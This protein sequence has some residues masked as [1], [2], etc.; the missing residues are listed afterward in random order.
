[1]QTH[2]HT[3]P[4][5]SAL[6]PRPFRRAAAAPGRSRRLGAAERHGRERRAATRGVQHQSEPLGSRQRHHGARVGRAGRTRGGGLEGVSCE[7]VR[8]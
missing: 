8:L 3:R 4:R 6:A 5:A 1:M 7:G 2:T